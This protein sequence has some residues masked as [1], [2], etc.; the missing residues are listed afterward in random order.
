MN[1]R[2]AELEEENKRLKN[3]IHNMITQFECVGCPCKSK[4]KANDSNTSY[5]D[6]MKECIETL[7]S[8]GEQNE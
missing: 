5:D 1:D 8:W 4:C 6:V 2:C 7:K 3:F